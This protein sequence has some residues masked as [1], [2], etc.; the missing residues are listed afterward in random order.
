[1][2]DNDCDEP[3]TG[4]IEIEN[5]KDFKIKAKTSFPGGRIHKVCVV[6]E[7]IDM[8]VGI[9]INIDQFPCS[10]TKNCPAGYEGEKAGKCNG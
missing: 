3:F 8:K 4:G 6:C 2:M 9:E 1:M 10:E 5:F 7:N